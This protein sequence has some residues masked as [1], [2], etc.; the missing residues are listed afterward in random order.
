MESVRKDVECFFGRLKQRFRILKGR[1]L[2]QNKQK[3]DNIFL[4]CVTLQNMLHEWDGLGNWKEPEVIEGE[5]EGSDAQYW[6]EGAPTGDLEIRKG[7]VALQ[8]R[9]TYVD[10]ST[11][12]SAIAIAHLEEDEEERYEELEAALVAHFSYLI[13]EGKS[14]GWLRSKSV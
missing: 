4:T 12:S 11:S 2:I 7:R 10:D 1:I 3:V 13:K 9:Q 8:G 6:S 14:N 5:I